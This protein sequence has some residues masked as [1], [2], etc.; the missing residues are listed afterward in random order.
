M[1]PSTAWTL[2]AFALPLASSALHGAISANVSL[3]R[4]SIIRGPKS[5]HGSAQERRATFL[6]AALSAG[7]LI[8]ALWEI[9]TGLD[10]RGPAPFRYKH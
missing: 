3:G 10:I 7:I 1:K 5:P 9:A 4:V 2:L 8:F 6:A